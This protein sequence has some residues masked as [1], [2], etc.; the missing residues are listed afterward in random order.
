MAYRK[1]GIIA[2][3]IQN[4]PPETNL[5][6]L[7]EVGF[8]CFFTH[9][10]DEATIRR[11]KKESEN[12]RLDFEFIHGPLHGSNDLWQA[13]DAYKPLFKE[14]LQTVDNAK[15]YGVSTV[16]LHVSS[17]WTPPPV[18]DVGLQ[19]FD[20]IVDYATKRGV[21]LAFENLRKLGNLACLMERYENEQ[22]VGFCYD[23]GHEHCYTKTVPFLDLY[24]DKLL[25][26]H[27][28]DNFGK[29]DDLSANDDLHL[30]PFDGNL[31][32]QK[33]AQ[34]CKEYGYAGSFML[35]V[36]NHRIY[37]T[38]SAKAFLTLAFERLK[39]LQDLG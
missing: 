17:G 8:D 19:R 37:E 14:I 3:C 29:T 11:L 5:P 28:H 27:I 12:L 32:F 13:G 31:D 35:E 36:F 2:D 1:L 23:C 26:T 16:I 34:K 9:H 21:K 24:H 39:K 33:V 6:L 7:K 10:T 38:M 4:Q 20:C 25:C 15:N 30:L 18:C 22:S